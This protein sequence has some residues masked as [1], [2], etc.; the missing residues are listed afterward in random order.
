M[1]AQD[2]V[3]K[4]HISIMRHKVFCAFSGV[5]ACGKVEVNDTTPTACT[6]GWDV[7]YG[8]QF[9]D[10]LDDAELRFVVLHETIHKSYQ[11]LNVWRNLWDE[12]KQL[13]NIACDHFVNLSLVDTDNGEGFLKMPK[14]GIQP[15]PQFRGWSVKQIYDHLKDEQD[16]D[17]ESGQGQGDGLDDHDFEGAG[18]QSAAEQAKQADEIQ[19]ALRQGEQVARARARGAG[20][21]GSSAL[22]GDLLKPQVN[23]REQLRDFVQAT[24]SGRDESTWAR[25]NR[26]FLADDIYLPSMESTTIGELIVGIDTSGSIGGTVITRFASELAAIVE[27]VRPERVRVVY[28]DWEV[29]GEQ[30]FEDGQFAVTQLKVKGG[31]GTDG[32]V[33]FDY[34]RS[35]GYKPAAIVQF[36]DG[37]VGS[38]GQSDVPVL[39]AITE[40]SIHAPYGV[41]VHITD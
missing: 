29:Q 17:D 41:T 39:W 35:K 2:R 15:E 37:L 40:R 10:S 9:V 12:N 26:R 27:Q 36:T 14:V 25:P 16:S 1:N 20:K 31:G 6:N 4:A 33:L 28:W 18:Q 11:H 21:G 3:K 5:L 32:S 22:I 13:A 30:V 23:W 38:F 7:S 34:V 8:T 19:R 24:C